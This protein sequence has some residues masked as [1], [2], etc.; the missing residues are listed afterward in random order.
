MFI[1][2]LTKQNKA[3]PFAIDI[4]GDMHVLRSNTILLLRVQT[5]TCAWRN[6]FTEIHINQ[7]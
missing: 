1:V 3:L 5:L 2:Y 7:Q 4:M 6:A